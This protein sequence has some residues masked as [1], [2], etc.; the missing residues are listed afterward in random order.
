[1]KIYIVSDTHGSTDF[2]ITN[3]LSNNDADL[4]IHLG[5]LVDDAS[6]IEEITGVQTICVSGNNDFFS[7]IPTDK[8]INFNNYRFLLTHGHKYG[9]N[10]GTEYLV[11]K[12]KELNCN[13]VLFGH[14]HRKLS[15]KIDGIYL[16][17]PGSASLP[18]DN[19]RKRSF[20][21]MNID[22]DLDVCFYFDR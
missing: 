9:V 20:V 11:Q 18:R 3:V 5:D 12:A 22:E 19:D 14:T 4:I 16:I 15:T 21:V 6:E 7:S 8:I 10:F 17:N 13:V 1:M 2:F